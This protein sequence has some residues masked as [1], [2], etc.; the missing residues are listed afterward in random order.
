ME[1]TR[2]VTGEDAAAILKIYSPYVKDTSIT[3][4]IDSPSEQEMK[5]RIEEYTEN[6]PWIV[7]DVD[8]VI[9]AY[10][11]AASFK[12]RAAYRWSVESSIPGDFVSRNKDGPF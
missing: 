4:E 1:F 12:A 2:A 6:F 11:Y 9:V 10:A 7:L 8:G 3:F 5:R